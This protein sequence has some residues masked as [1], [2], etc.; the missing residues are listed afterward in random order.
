M[1]KQR[2][3]SLI[4]L[5]IVILILGLLLG[6]L[7]QPLST[8]MDVSRTKDTEKKLTD[9]Q[10]ALYGFAATRGRLPCPA[11]VASLGDEAPVAPATGACTAPYDGFVP[12]RLLGLGPLDANGFVTDA[13]GN[14]IRYAVTQRI[15]GANNSLTLGGELRTIGINAYLTAGDTPANSI[16]RVCAGAAGTTP[17]DCGPV[18]NR[19]TND[20]VAVLI[21]EGP[22]GGT[23][24][25][26]SSADEAANRDT[27]PIFV[28]QTRSQNF[29]HIVQWIP[30]GLLVN[31][32]MTAGQLP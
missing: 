17:N 13:W 11:T 15:S 32:M 1:K 25:V 24:S 27:V 5:S 12:G 28:S 3:F 19:L 31:R 18:A 2:G 7:M 9:I 30:F 4:E 6:G 29:D 14:P 16:L 22:T 20:A 26:A 23:G 8:Q 21:S 10:D